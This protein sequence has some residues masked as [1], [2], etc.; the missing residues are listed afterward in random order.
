MDTLPTVWPAEDHTK[1]KHAILRR[2][3]S[4]WLPILTQQTSAVG[5]ALQQVLYIDGFAGP[6]EYVGGEP[7]SPVI[8]LREALNHVKRFPLPVKFVFVEQRE[9]RFR[10]LSDVIGRYQRDIK[11][12]QNVVVE[13]PRQGDCDTAISEILSTYERQGVRFGPALAF[14]DQFG[15]SAVSMDMISKIMEYPQCEVFSYLDYKDMNRWITDPT[16]AIAFDRAFGGDEWRGAISLPE[17]KRRAF[18]LD[19]YQKLLRHRAGVRYVQ[20]FAMFDRTGVLLYWLLFCTN[21]IRGLEE[22][23]RAM[24]AVDG[25]GGFRFSDRDDPTQLKLL[26]EEFDQN[27]LAE[28][29]AE[30][31]SGK[32]I[33]VGEVKGYVLENTPC[34]LYKDALGKLYSEKRLQIPRPPKNWRRGTFPDEEMAVYFTRPLF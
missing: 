27:W 32:E 2:Y 5:N 26:A 34:Y 30:K 16:K 25:S 14:L 11:K 18:L 31:L 23:K 20:S 6:G 22:M 24:W 9:D 13:D 19:L 21:N 4:A 33:T 3:L 1:A 29:L 10:N 17:K 28:V 12:S 8:A 7:G 15:Y